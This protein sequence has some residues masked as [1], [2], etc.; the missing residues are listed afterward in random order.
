[1]AGYRGSRQR[2]GESASGYPRLAY[3]CLDWLI[4]ALTGLFPP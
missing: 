4:R 3:L 1:M 2:G